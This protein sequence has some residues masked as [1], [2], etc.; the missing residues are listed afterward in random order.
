MDERVALVMEGNIKD[1]FLRTLCKITSLET[2][3]NCIII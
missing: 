1:I 2:S 3:D